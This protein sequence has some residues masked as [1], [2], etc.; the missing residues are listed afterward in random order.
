MTTS[1]RNYP[2]TRTYTVLLAEDVPHYGSIEIIATS[3]REALETARTLEHSEICLQ[4]DRENP[5]CRRIVHVEAE[6]GSILAE[7][8]ALD[9][10]VL[11]HETEVRAK[12]CAMAPVL[13]T[14]L[15][16]IALTPL[17]GERVENPALREEFIAFG[18]YDAARDEFEPSADTESTY[19]RDVVEAARGALASRAGPELAGS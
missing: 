10:Y 14:A 11:H 3:D 2:G 1:K 8:V 6:D 9:R 18:E 17:W 15:E 4:P 12:L 13:Q 5:V 16:L 19:L 7:G